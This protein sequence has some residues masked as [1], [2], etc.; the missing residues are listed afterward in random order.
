MARYGTF[1]E[2]VADAVLLQCAAQAPGIK[3]LSILCLIKLLL[4][5]T[6]IGLVT[7]AGRRWGPK[8][9]GWLSAFP[10]IAGPILLFVALDHG[11]EFAATAA[12]GTLSAVL[13]IVVFSLGYSW[14]AMR[15]HWVGCLVVALLVYFI[16]VLGLAAVPMS[17][18][19][20]A[21]LALVSVVV[22]P[23][24]FPVVTLPVVKIKPVRYDL[25]LRMIL[26]AALVMLIT[27]SA[28]NLGPR[29]AGI[30]MMF[31]VMS[32]ILTV[33]SHR[34]AGREFAILF[35]KGMMLGWYS[36]STFCFTLAL[37][38]HGAGVAVAFV[39]AVLAAAIVQLGSRRFLH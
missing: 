30:L 12:T 15:L 17:L 9:A 29:L 8:V 25:P 24:L 16:A 27:Y 35:L 28:H 19:Q 11:A 26:G 18:V 4:V 5:P 32:S 36:F 33:F 21:L 20:A 14:A 38:L 22:A 6:L 31:P 37:L 10:I 23:R 39:L 7:L 34:S 13:A 2:G 3:I 1:H